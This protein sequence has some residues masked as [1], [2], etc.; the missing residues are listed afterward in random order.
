MEEDM[1]R[2]PSKIRKSI[3]SL[4]EELEYL[5]EKKKLLEEEARVKIA[6]KE[7]HPS[8]KRQALRT[9]GKVL[10]QAR[11][12]IKKEVRKE[13]PIIKAELKKRKAR[14]KRKYGY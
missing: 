11:M 7:L 1:M 8:K 2:P 9:I 13:L 12:E 14:R 3:E 4:R 5:R 6:L 10:G